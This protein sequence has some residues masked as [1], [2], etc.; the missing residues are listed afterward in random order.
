MKKRA[1]LIHGW[2]GSPNKD[3]MP[4]A[5]KELEQKDF[6]V[7]VPALPETEY[8]K[9]EAWV[10]YLSRVIGESKETDILIGHS[11][12]CQTILRFFRNF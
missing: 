10:L 12:G 5:K 1:F 2:G 3:W 6:E 11:M 7:I 4:W 9:I 8:P